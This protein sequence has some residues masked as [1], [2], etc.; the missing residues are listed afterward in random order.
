MSQIIVCHNK[1]C[2]FRLPIHQA[3]NKNGQLFCSDKCANGCN[4]PDTDKRE[5]EQKENMA[6]KYWNI[7]LKQKPRPHPLNE[8]PTM[9]FGVWD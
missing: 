6:Q 1:A 3:K 7:L 5:G 2:R 8:I 9:E 4:P